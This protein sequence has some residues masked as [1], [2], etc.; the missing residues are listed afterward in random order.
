VDLDEDD[1]QSLIATPPITPTTHHKSSKRL[2]TPS[3]SPHTCLTN[4]R[5]PSPEPIQHDSRPLSPSLGSSPDSA[6]R[7]SKRARLSPTQDNIPSIS[8]T[9]N[10]AHTESA[11]IAAE[12]WVHQLCS[13]GDA[14]T[15]I[16]DHR[17]N[18]AERL[19]EAPSEFH[20]WLQNTVVPSNKT[21]LR[22]AFLKITVCS[23]LASD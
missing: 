19:N 8:T 11:L 2:R 21:L 15:Y 16:T 22:Q 9:Q 3:P 23:V 12:S 7:C 17:A 4:A 18:I 14:I 6:L 10:Q 5:T 1:N 20:Q 13:F